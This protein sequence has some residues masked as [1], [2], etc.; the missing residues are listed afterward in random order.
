[1][2]QPALLLQDRL[3][4]NASAIVVPQVV[5]P[6]LALCDGTR[7]TPAIMAAMELWT[8]IRLDHATVERLLGQLDDA[9]MLDNER[10]AGAYQAALDDYRSAPFRPA[11]LAGSSYPSDASALAALLDRWLS[12]ASRRNGT[13]SRLDGIRGVVCPHIDY[14]RGGQVYGDVWELARGAVAEADHFV[15]LGT[16]HSGGPGELTLTRQHFQTPF[17]VLKTDQAAV[18]SV[19]TAMGTEAAFRSE[20]NHRGEHSVEL[21]AVWLHYLAGYRPISILPVLCG[22]FQPFTD[23]GAHPSQDGRWQA[24]V[25]A[26]RKVVEEKRS[27]VVV[28]ADLAHMGPAFGDP[29]PL[30]DEE[31]ARLNIADMEMLEV[32]CGGD[33]D[34]FLALLAAEKD[35]RKVCGLPPI[36][37]ALQLLGDARADLV[38]YA[39]CPASGGSMVSV[40]GILLG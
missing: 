9:L 13:S 25:A 30:Q 5:V 20:L 24:A 8:G 29:A 40:A 4:P 12:R 2:G 21:A 23:G 16:D 17:G 37:L 36:Y 10:F 32:M 1:M 18:E 22:S 39:Q 7:D 3:V 11:A 35:Q 31:K 34:A 27:L 38:S 19:A 33:A 26:I 14:D 6:L 28:A 15:I